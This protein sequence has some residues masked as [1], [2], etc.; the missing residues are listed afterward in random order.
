[1]KT[2]CLKAIAVCAVVGFLSGN[3]LNA[4]PKFNEIDGMPIHSQADLDSLKTGDTV[5]MVCSTCNGTEM[6]TYSKDPSSPRHVKWMQSDFSKTCKM[7]GGKLT[8]V[9]DGD[10]IKYVCEKC[11][12]PAFM[13]AFKTASR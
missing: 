11:S 5:A 1:M 13:T 6:T 3:S 4:E 9:K 2:A 7:C 8:A 12:G 10:Q